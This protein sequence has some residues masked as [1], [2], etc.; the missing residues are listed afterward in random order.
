MVSHRPPFHRLQRVQ[1]R[2]GQRPC[3][4]PFALLRATTTQASFTD[5]LST[6]TTFT[7]NGLAFD[8]ANNRLLW[9]ENSSPAGNTQIRASVTG[10]SL[11]SPS[12]V[13]TGLNMEIDGLQINSKGNLIAIDAATG[14]KLINLGTGALGTVTN[15]TDGVAC[16]TTVAVY[17]A[18]AWCSDAAGTVIRLVGAGDL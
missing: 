14:A 13:I 8:T 10:A 11:S 1:K 15:L 18:D 6:S 12:S 3:D 7:L 17:K 4:H 5:W 16:A 9:A 2:R